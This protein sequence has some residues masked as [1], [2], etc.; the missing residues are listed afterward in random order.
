MSQWCHPVRLHQTQTAIKRL[1][2]RQGLGFSGVT[3]LSGERMAVM[4][5]SGV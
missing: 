1:P 3:V 4:V 5:F 2:V